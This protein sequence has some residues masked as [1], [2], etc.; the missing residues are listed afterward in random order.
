[1]SMKTDDSTNS[2]SASV[3]PFVRSCGADDSPVPAL[4]PSGHSPSMH[5]RQFHNSPNFGIANHPHLPAIPAPL[6]A[7]PRQNYGIVNALAGFPSNGD[8]IPAA[9]TTAAPRSPEKTRPFDPSPRP[10]KHTNWNWRFAAPRHNPQ[11]AIAAIRPLPLTCA[12]G[13]LKLPYHSGA[14]PALRFAAAFGHAA[15]ARPDH[16]RFDC[17]VSGPGQLERAAPGSR[18]RPRLILLPLVA[19]RLATTLCDDA[20][21]VSRTPVRRTPMRCDVATQQIHFYRRDQS[22]RRRPTSIEDF[23]SFSVLSVPP[24]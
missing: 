23:L 3:A 18:H 21:R 13:V 15:S 17:R 20:P 10:A 1:M 16:S 4:Q 12:R 7:P 8:K 19:I 24:R 2:S 22:T 9:E 11:G 5:T 6:P 14:R